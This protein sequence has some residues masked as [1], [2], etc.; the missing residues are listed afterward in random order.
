M[1]CLPCPPGPPRLPGDGARASSTAAVSASSRISPPRPGAVTRSRAAA[2]PA[3]PPSPPRARPR[4]RPGPGPARPAGRTSVCLRPPWARARSPRSFSRYLRVSHF[5]HSH[6]TDEKTEVLRGDDWTHGIHS[7]K[8][9]RGLFAYQTQIL[10]RGGHHGACLWGG[11][12][13]PNAVAAAL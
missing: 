9:I 4:P 11:V 10:L 5:H 13:L 12:K 8:G 7:D 2:R 1:V 3:W 6:F